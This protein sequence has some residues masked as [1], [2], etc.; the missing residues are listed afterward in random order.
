[1]FEIRVST[2][3]VTNQDGFPQ[4][5]AELRIGNERLVFAIDLRHWSIPDYE[6]QWREGIWRILEGAP[7]SALITAYAGPTGHMHHMWALWREEKSMY[8]QQHAIINGELDHPFVPNN[9][10]AYVGM[11]IEV[12]KYDLPIREWR[13][14][15]AAI[16]AAARKIA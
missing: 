7:N 15:L 1:M 16:F 8:V 4:A 13:V 11:R 5:G 12:S 9:P 6:V 14:S 10:Y 2:P 3:S